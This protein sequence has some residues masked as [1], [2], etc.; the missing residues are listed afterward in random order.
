MDSKGKTARVAPGDLQVIGAGLPRTGTTSLYTALE[1]LG[2]DRCHHFK[3]SIGGNWFPYT[4]SRQWQ[5][6]MQTDDA[7]TRRKIIKQIY[8]DAGCR[9]AVDYPS[10]AFISDLVE[11]YPDAKFVHSVRSS[12]LA[13]R[14]SWNSTLDQI[15]GRMMYWS[16]FLIPH[17]QWALFPTMYG[18]LTWDEKRLGTTLNGAD[19]DITM[20]ERHNEYVRKVV[21]KDR[22]LEFEPKMGFGPLCK[23]L[24]VPIPTDDQGNELPYPHVNDTNEL[25]KG[26]KVLRLVGLVHW[27]LLGGAVWGTG[28]ASGWW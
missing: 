6:A 3:N 12:P 27:A 7:A 8:R 11:I 21:P 19:D 9:S 24:E 15:Y 26:I 16:C 28:K 23:F 25:Q 13:W 5:K 18:F 14:K 2:Y 17:M 4:Q 10:S 1:M 20:Y 22:L